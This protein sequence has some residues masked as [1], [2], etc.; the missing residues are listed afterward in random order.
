MPTESLPSTGHTS[1]AGPTCERGHSQIPSESMS[2]AAGSPVRIFP[3]PEQGQGLTVPAVDCFSRPFAWLCWKTW[4]RCL[5]GDWTEFSGRWP[6]SG[7]MRNGIAYRL[8]PLV[9]RTF[10]TG[11]SFWPTPN[12]AGYRS[13]GE[14]RCLQRLVSPAELVGMTERAASSNG[15]RY[16]PTPTTRDHKG[17]GKHGLARNGVIQTDT[18]DRAV[19]QAEPG[20]N[21]GSLNPP[22]VEWLMGFPLGW[23]DCEDLET[24]S[25]P[26]SQNGSADDL[27]SQKEDE[28]S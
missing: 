8:P 26:K 12:V 1:D 10:V 22:W 6:R 28:I 9:P 11:F 13:D 16:W 4:Q 23:T 25:C 17:C 3:T 7:M 20:P 15:A 21:N 27:S 24:P 18:L 19:W 2:S 5:L 14:L